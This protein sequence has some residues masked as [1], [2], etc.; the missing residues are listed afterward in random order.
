MA[1]VFK[2]KLFSLEDDYIKA[3]RD[4][5]KRKLKNK[6][7]RSKMTGAT[8]GLIPGMITGVGASEALAE[9]F[10]L[11]ESTMNT[12]ALIGAI[13]GGLGTGYLAGKSVKRFHDASNESALIN[14][15]HYYKIY[16]K[17][18][19]GEIDYLDMLFDKPAATKEIKRLLSL[20]IKDPVAIRYDKLLK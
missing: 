16:Y 15:G 3:I 8:M 14:F 4:E 10:N 13:V 6:M 19:K 9:K 1:L 5:N 12:G 18:S 17:N 11:P 7:I 2:T 20:G